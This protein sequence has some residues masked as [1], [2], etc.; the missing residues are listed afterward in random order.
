MTKRIT[1]DAT[2][3]QLTAENGMKKF[4]FYA[5]SG[6]TMYPKLALKWDGPVVVD[7]SGVAIDAPQKPVHMDHDISRPVGHTIAIQAENEIVADGIF[8]LDNE[9]SRNIVISGEAGFPWKCSIGLGINEYQIYEQGQSATV[10][11][12]DFAGPVLVVTSSVLEEISFVT[13]PGDAESYAEVM[14]RLSNGEAV[15]PTF[16]EWIASLGLDVSAIS[17]ELKMVLQKQY[18]EAA[19][20]M[21]EAPEVVAQEGQDVVAQEGEEMKPEMS[22]MSDEEKMNAKAKANG[23]I[24]LKAQREM[25]A[26]EQARVAD[27]REFCSKN[28][29]PKVSVS[30]KEV[31]L[32]AH[33]I[34]QGWSVKDTEYA[35]LKHERLQATRKGRPQVPG[36]HTK[37]SS[38]V[39]KQVL[40]AAC[41][42]RA[43]IDVESKKWSHKDLREHVPS[44][45]RADIN[46]DAKQQILD[47]AYKFRGESMIDMCAHS[48][49]AAGKEVPVGRMNILQA[50][51]STGAV[52]DLYG[53]T[54]GAKVLDGY[55]EV[56]DFSEGWVVEGE[57][58]DMTEHDRIRM[59]A[60]G[61][62][63]YLP[64]GGEAQHARRATKVEKAKVERFAKQME[65]DEADILGDNFGKLKETPRDFGLAAGRVR[66]N[67]VASIILDNPTLNATSR[68]L[69]NTTDGN[70]FGSAALSRA[71]LS[72]AIAAMKKFKDG[73]AIL[74]LEP[75]HLLVPPE[76]FDLAVQL[77]QS[78]RNATTGSNE[79]EL[80]PL[81]A[82]NIQ[83]VSEARLSLGL[84][85]PVSKTSHAGSA[86]T[87]YLVSNQAH[88]IECTYMQSAG[89]A[90]IVRTTELTNGRFGVNFDVR[91]YVGAV[92]LDWR[93]FVYNQSG[94]L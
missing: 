35:F 24:D 50:A 14:A 3:V 75:T 77:T 12:R 53:Q 91:L 47:T 21:A 94:A 71:T 13:V 36:I 43:G 61:D 63:A 62:L 80:N 9:D 38:D 83:V 70:K 79:G 39:S 92:A 85:D 37:A 16:E 33:A 59:E 10:N 58:P 66:P 69:F 2:R 18:A 32:C 49:R 40:Q 64:I 73:D 55:S 51:F 15:M 6:G 93:G 5:Y 45:L 27:V 81:S 19:E 20:D 82:Y 44:W 86:S 34:K 46:S 56:R 11:G 52:S 89:R 72:A 7:V 42:L 76:L 88:T 60:A 29:N 23:K 67:L 65:I 22:A 28:D 90:P 17:D 25:L 57:N 84:V 54:F 30:G 31:D 87:W 41:A 8:S 68:D 26:A 1:L 4:H 48:L 74:N 78:A